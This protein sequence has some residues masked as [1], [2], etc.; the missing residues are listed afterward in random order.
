VAC[1]RLDAFWAFGENSV[2]CMSGALL[3]REAG[4]V[5]TQAD[6]APYGLASLS[7]AAAPPAVHASVLLRLQDV[8]VA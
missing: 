6:G 4:G 8:M 7:I 5:A 2:D 3:V 1:G